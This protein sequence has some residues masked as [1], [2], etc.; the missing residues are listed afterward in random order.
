VYLVYLGVRSLISGGK[1]FDLLAKAGNRTTVWKAFRQG[2]LVDI[3]N[4]KVAIF[5]MAFLPQVIRPEMGHYSAQI[6]LLGFLVILVAVPI[7]L[8]FVMTAARTTSYF[9]ENPRCSLWIERLSGSVLVALGI[10]LALSK[11]TNA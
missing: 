7:E 2:V 11:N 9:R 3:F 4:P 6:A 8:F 1:T 10:R 5:F